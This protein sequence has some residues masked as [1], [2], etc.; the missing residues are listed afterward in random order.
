ML[1]LDSSAA[2]T[3]SPRRASSPAQRSGLNVLEKSSFY[4]AIREEK[5]NQNPNRVTRSSSSKED[6]ASETGAFQP[7]G[8][9]FERMWRQWKKPLLIAAGL[10]TVGAGGIAAFWGG[11]HFMYENIKTSVIPKREELG[12]LWQRFLNCQII[13]NQQKESSGNDMAVKIK[14]GYYLVALFQDALDINK[15]RSFEVTEQEKT[16]KSKI[17]IQTILDYALDHEQDVLPVLLRRLHQTQRLTEFLDETKIP[18]IETPFK[19]Y[20]DKNEAQALSDPV[21]K[22]AFAR[23]KN[24]RSVLVAF[25]HYSSSG[26]ASRT[27]QAAR[28]FQQERKGNKAESN[29][30]MACI[31]DLYT[32]YLK[33]YHPHAYDALIPLAKKL[34]DEDPAAPSTLVREDLAKLSKSTKLTVQLYP[35]EDK[36]DPIYFSQFLRDMMDKII[37]RQDITPQNHGY[38]RKVYG[39]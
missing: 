10:I 5:K 38:H 24:D 20:V 27:V 23:Y 26:D 17:I 14:A 13:L 29:F 6:S 11:S 33:V 37:A 35:W 28:L 3:P 30:E 34:Q 31:L 12:F 4:T 32:T 15:F 7:L 19:G 25:K 16:K 36:N 39:N 1:F 21:L 18:M 9:Q 8:K 22:I 2:L